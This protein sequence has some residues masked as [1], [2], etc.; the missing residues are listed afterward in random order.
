V[1]IT[2]TFAPPTRVPR[3][4]TTFFLVGTVWVDATATTSMTPVRHRRGEVGP[5]QGTISHSPQTCG[6]A[7][8]ITSAGTY[9]VTFS[10][11]TI[12][13][14]LTRTVTV[15]STSVLLDL[16]YAGDSTV[17]EANTGAATSVDSS[18]AVLH[19]TAIPNGSTTTYYF[20]YGTTTGYGL[21]TT[22]R[23]T[24]IDLA[25]SETIT[26]LSA[27]TTYHYRLVTT[28]ASG[29][30]YGPDRSFQTAAASSGSS[31]GGGG[32]GGGPCLIAVAREGSGRTAING[33]L[34]PD[35]SRASRGSRRRTDGR[36]SSNSVEDRPL[37]M[38]R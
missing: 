37:S 6:Y 35:C 32:G 20:Q 7:I 31:G 4:N 2:G 16:K 22:S 36:L 30:S 14:P 1:V 5:D 8:P 34:L 27:N 13:A 18:T 15:G 38:R 29:T 17:P 23:T 19:G 3:T 10:G 33:W 28:N 9:E 21:Q 12:S 11:S 26:A 25:V 24:G